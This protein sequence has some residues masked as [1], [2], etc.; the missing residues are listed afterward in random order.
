MNNV[1]STKV[2]IFRNVKDF[3][4][5]H[6]LTNENKQ[7]IIE[8]LEK[9]LKGKMSYINIENA[10]SNVLNHLISQNLICKNTKDLFIS[11]DNIS[12]NLFTGE[13]IEVLSTCC[14]YDKN[15]IKKAVE[16]SN[17]LSG[18]ISFSFNDEYGYL[19][20]DLKKVGAGI[21][22]ESDIMLSAITK[23]NKIEQV[24]QNIAKLGYTLKETKYPA[25][26]TLSTTCNLGIGE[27]KLFEDF[28]STLTKL[29]DLETESVKMID[30]TEHDVMLDK[31]SRS[32]AILN[33]AH[34]LTYDELYNI[35]VNLRMGLN[36]GI[37]DIKLEKLNKLQSL[38]LNKLNEIA[39]QTEL[40]ELASKAKEIVKGE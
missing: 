10:D 11:K 23:I 14:G 20:S 12:I 5:A 25:V 6:K 27:K 7:Q 4:F 9:A 21:Q 32:L 8:I 24:K 31:T 22:I 16:L 34:L 40:K 37:V 28:E 29:Q 33:A 18:K 3:K 38:V 1:I 15:V 36:L 13:H 2:A 35:I 30:A 17:F 19:M 39:S 26:Y